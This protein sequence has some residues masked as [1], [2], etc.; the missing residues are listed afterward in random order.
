MTQG[1]WIVDDLRVHREKCSSCQVRMSA[2]NER[3]FFIPLTE[4]CSTGRSLY[5]AWW[6]WAFELP[7][8]RDE[9]DA[10]RRLVEHDRRNPR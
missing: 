9:A 4:L 6:E 3:P 8:P 7:Y 2:P 1:S 5:R 10:A